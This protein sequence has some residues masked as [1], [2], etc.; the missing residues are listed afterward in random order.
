MIG[1][2]WGILGER[3][4]SLGTEGPAHNF[5]VF[6]G[7]LRPAV[8]PDELVDIAGG[9][10]LQPRENSIYT[11]APELG[12]PPYRE[13]VQFGRMIT[14]FCF[15]FLGPRMARRTGYRCDS[16]YRNSLGRSISSRTF[17]RLGPSERCDA[18]KSIHSER[19]WTPFKATTTRYAGS[20][21][22][23]EPNLYALTSLSGPPSLP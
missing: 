2:R 13:A 21:C 4:G 16:A 17:I 1:E 15:R 5:S 19:F 11:L 8:V 23:K 6:G 3:W 12:G 9:K 10:R 14:F 20:R 18:A 22:W 7:L